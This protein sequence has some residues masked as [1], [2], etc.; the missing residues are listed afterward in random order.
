[1]TENDIARLLIKQHGKKWLCIPQCKTEPR[2]FENFGERHG[3]RGRMDLWCMDNAVDKP[4][5]EACEIKTSRADFLSDIRTDKWKKY[6][7][8]CNLFSFVVSSLEVA[9]IYD[10]PDGVGLKSVSMNGKSIVTILRPMR[11]EI[12]FPATVMHY[13]LLKRTQ[14]I[15][16]RI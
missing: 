8:Y 4:T 6:L 2:G 3:I 16:R 9:G 1:M 15:E 7:P 10:L 14:I 11:R 12:G 13:V 5:F